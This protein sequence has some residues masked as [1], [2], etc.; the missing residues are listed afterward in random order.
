MISD[1]FYEAHEDA[2]EY[3]DCEFSLYTGDIRDRIEKCLA[4]I[5]AI[6]LALDAP[7]VVEEAPA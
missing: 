5:K 1:V 6:Q 3:L 4:E 2:R 7:P